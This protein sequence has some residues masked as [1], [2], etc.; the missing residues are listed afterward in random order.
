MRESGSVSKRE[1]VVSFLDGD[2]TVLCAIVATP[3]K[4]A[5]VVNSYYPGAL[6]H[7]E[8]HLCTQPGECV[9]ICSPDCP[10]PRL[11]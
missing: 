2:A 8:L 10:G 3:G 4:V 9:W 5:I 1:K 11:D 6:E 7:A